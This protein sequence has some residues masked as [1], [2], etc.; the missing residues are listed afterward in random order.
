MPKKRAMKTPKR[1]F[2]VPNV[3]LK[4]P[5]IDSPDSNDPSADIESATAGSTPSPC[6]SDERL[7]HGNVRSTDLSNQNNEGQNVRTQNI[8]TRFDAAF[9][10]V[11]AEK[12]VYDFFVNR[13]S[14]RLVEERSS[15]RS[16]QSD[17]QDMLGSVHQLMGEIESIRADPSQFDKRGGAS[18]TRGPPLPSQ[19]ELFAKARLNGQVRVPY[20]ENQT[21]HVT[22]TECNK[23]RSYYN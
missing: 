14:K 19:C 10:D 16:V 4:A 6:E 20:Q 7:D 5:V 21:C 11:V 3:K 18:R 17:L 22:Y 9:R 2:N 15:T 13:M 23:R 12:R 1:P 8:E